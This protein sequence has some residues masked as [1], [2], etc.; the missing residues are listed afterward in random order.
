MA[1]LQVVRDYHAD[2]QIPT[3]AGTD[4]EAL[5]FVNFGE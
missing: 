1:V 4:R 5:R 3:L 2:V